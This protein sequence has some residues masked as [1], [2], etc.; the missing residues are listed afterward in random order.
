[1][2]YRDADA[3][4]WI[5]R[6]DESWR[7]SPVLGSVWNNMGHT[8]PDYHQWAVSQRSFEA[9]GAWFVTTGVL[10]TDDGT[11]QIAA[12]RAT[13]SLIPLL[14]TRLALGRW[15]LPGE[16]VR[17][18]R[19]QGVLS[20]ESWQRR[21]AGDSAIVGRRLTLDGQ[22]TEV[23][24]ILPRG[25][26]IAG[27]TSLVEVWTPAG[28]SAGE[29]QP[30]NYNYRVVGRLRSSVSVDAAAREATQL[31]TTS[32]TP[33]QTRTRLEHL[34]TETIRN[35]RAPLAV[36]L[37]AAVLLLVIA[38]GNIATLL[39]GDA[40]ARDAE[41][42]LRVS[43]G[44]TPGRVVRQLL[45]ENLLLA[46]IGGTL[47]CAAAILIVRLL[48]VLAPSGIP[49]IE[50]AHVD[51][52]TLAFAIAVTIAT[53]VTFSLAPLAAVLRASPASTMR[54]GS[55]RLTQQRG[56]LERGG[57][58]VQT[59]LVVVLLAGAALLVR[60]HQ[61]LTAVDPG[62]RASSILSI[63]LRFLPPV[64]RYRDVA[65]R[66]AVLDEI[67]T[68]L[69]ALPGVERA[70][71]AFAVPFQGMSSTSI[72]IGGSAVVSPEDEI[73]GTYIVA[74]P[75]FFETMG[76]ALRAGRLLEPVDDAPGSAVVLSETMARRFWP[77]ASAI[78]RQIRIDDVWRDVVGVVADV[79]HRSVDEEP[80]ATFYL[81]AAQ[82]TN[83]V[84]D[85]VVLRTAGDPRDQI[86]AARR[87]VAE[88]DPTL[89]IARAD[90]LSDLVDA[91]LVAERFRMVLLVVFAVAAMVLAAI[92]IVGVATN[93]VSRRTR[94]LAIRMAVGAPPSLAVGLVMS[95]TLAA[96]L[97]GTASGIALALALTRSLRPFLYDVSSADPSTYGAVSVT[98][99]AIA[100]MATWIPAW[101]STKL[102]LMRTLGAD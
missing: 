15:F 29:W 53:A 7:A 100:A 61:E 91:T 99:V 74:A 85:A 86:A 79:R 40:S 81:P 28:I 56:S 6:T 62:F 14:G 82:T 98:I 52:R 46:T 22:P 70:S 31:L 64:T 75:G 55:A 72:R 41:I 30:G 47:G 36:L 10:S 3:L 32:D 34:Q 63:R 71:P 4:Y 5:A 39:I 51:I 101:R 92:G 13:S 80:R 89:P 76:I 20:F 35:L 87:V 96:S 11:E 48:R 97:G 19:R 12:G 93:T 17:D 95:G 24:G 88:V 49:R 65:S 84:L 50:L 1:L 73:A 102:D 44:A 67:A 59:A 27:D 69:A 66:R 68:K 33:G 16:D 43:L 38:C 18:G 9:S 37:A 57:V 90:R 26:R 2:P 8:L 42:A 94:E 77:N 45:T 23:V 54:A 78:G 21:Y 83:R 58:F 25:F 60:T